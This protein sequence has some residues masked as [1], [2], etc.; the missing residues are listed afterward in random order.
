MNDIEQS[1][2]S[3]SDLGLIKKNH[4]TVR[5]GLESNIKELIQRIQQAEERANI[6]GKELEFVLN[7]VKKHEEKIKQLN[8][9]LD[10]SKKLS[11][12]LNKSF[13]K[14]ET[15]NTQMTERI[16][17]LEALLNAM[18]ERTRAKVNKD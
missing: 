3:I 15:Q 10:S 5:P 2:S 8:Q 17:G 4:Q 13:A 6:A 7:I 14:M 18:S 12:M 16:T 9:E 1:Y 11:E